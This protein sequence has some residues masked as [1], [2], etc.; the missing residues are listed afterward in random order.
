MSDKP[1]TRIT[2]YENDY[3]TLYYYPDAKI[4]YHVLHKFTYGEEFRRYLELGL[5]LL[6]KHG[7]RKWIADNRNHS[8]LPTEDLEWSMNDWFFRAYKTGWRYWA[9]VMPD[10]IAGQL[11]MNRIMKR[12]IDMGMT[13]KVVE[14]LEEAL[15]W[16]ALVE[17]PT[18]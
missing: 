17:A 10:K 2:V 8:A 13:I 12:N 4:V 11:S 9:M 7:A 18:P 6:Q 1:A 16:L 3:V 14:S 5:E 15:E